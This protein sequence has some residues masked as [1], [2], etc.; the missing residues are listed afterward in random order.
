MQASQDYQ[1]L[2]CGVSYERYSEANRPVRIKIC[3]HLLCQNCVRE[4]IQRRMLKCPFCKKPFTQADA[5]PDSPDRTSWD[6]IQMMLLMLENNRNHGQTLTIQEFQKTYAPLKPT[7]NNIIHLAQ[8]IVCSYGKV[9]SQAESSK[10]FRYIS[11]VLKTV[12]TSLCFFPPTTIAGFIATGV[13]LG[14]DL[15]YSIMNNEKGAYLRLS[16]VVLKHDRLCCTPQISALFSDYQALTA[17]RD[18]P[19]PFAGHLSAD[20]S[21][22]QGEQNTSTINTGI[23]SVN[24]VK[25]GVDVF[26]QGEAIEQGVRAFSVMKGGADALKVGVTTLSKSLLV[27]GLVVQWGVVIYQL[28]QENDQ[29]EYLKRRIAETRR[30]IQMFQEVLQILDEVI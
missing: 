14:S 21:Y 28:N 10:W 22:L 15:T 2:E 26:N 24:T 3:D 18:Q 4:L 13:L 25:L 7:L 23:Q 11:D 12:S 27:G 1:I 20:R 29:I 19:Q 8:A 30:A 5:N 17:T 6:F 9:I 16:D